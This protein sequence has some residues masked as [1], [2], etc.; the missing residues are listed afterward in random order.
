MDAGQ[1]IWLVIFPF[2]YSLLAVYWL[3]K[4]TLAPSVTTIGGQTLPN[5]V[6]VPDSIVQPGVLRPLMEGPLR[7]WQ[8]LMYSEMSLPLYT[9]LHMRITSWIFEVITKYP[10]TRTQLAS[11]RLEREKIRKMR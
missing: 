2:P 4:P 1:V 10:N 6:R 5:L 7:P 11:R 8:F 3:S 9:L